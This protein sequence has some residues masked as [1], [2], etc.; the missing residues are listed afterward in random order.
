MLLAIDTKLLSAEAPLTH[1]EEE[2]TRLT[3]EGMADVSAGR[4]FSH[5]A[6]KLWARSRERK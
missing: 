5:A 2:R 1:D 6:V 3:L 4:V